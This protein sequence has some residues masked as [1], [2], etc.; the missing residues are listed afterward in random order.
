MVTEKELALSIV[1]TL[2]YFDIFSYP[3]TKEELFLNL[4]QPPTGWDYI[5]FVNFLG[6]NT[7]N[8]LW[9]EKWGFYFLKDKEKNIENRRDRQLASVLKLKAAERAAKKLRSI[10][11]L[12]AIFICNTVAAGQA[13]E[14]SDIDFFIV[15][16]KG[17]IWIVR[18]FANL[19]LRFFGL[20]TYG[21][22]LRDR[23]CLSF[24]VDRDNLNLK[25]LSVLEPDIHFIY[26][27]SQMIPLYDPT[28]IIKNFKESN[29]WV[30]ESIPNFFEHD[31][32]V[33][34]KAV[35]ENPLGKI[36]RRFWEISWQGSYGDYIE[37]EARK[38]QIMKLSLAVK[39]AALKPNKGVV[40][41]RGVIKLHEEDSREKIQEQWENNLSSLVP[42]SYDEQSH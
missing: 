37:T 15:A 20:R 16:E 22:K 1:K 5:S 12:R 24:F 36:W 26:W 6:G 25:P 9:N 39:Q 8:D 32:V 4:W 17:R 3:L 41:D 14:D 7:N 33:Y 30:Q 19:V 31:P 18:L 2:S 35:R 23:I 40:V 10:P 29:R 21:E 34:L 27:L 38:I 13:K 42:F 11:F 28:G